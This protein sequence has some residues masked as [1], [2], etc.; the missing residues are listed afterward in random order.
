M[1]FSSELDFM[2][3]KLEAELEN[4]L[5]NN[6]N[7]GQF[8]IKL[9]A[10]ENL[11]TKM[12]LS[13]EENLHYQS[14]LK[15]LKKRSRTIAV[16]KN[17]QKMHNEREMRESNLTSRRIEQNINPY[18]DMADD[19]FYRGENSRLDQ[20]V[21]KGLDSL[22]SLRRQDDLINN[23]NTKLRSGIKRLGLSEEFI[24]NIENRAFGDKTLFVFLLA[25]VIILM[26]VLRFFF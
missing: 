25:F 7:I 14:L 18:R 2:L 23:V 12:K 19:D 9:K 16:E 17:K 26:F 13:E 1:Q 3:E 20:I 5:L 4:C 15:S 6:K 11:L 22:A 8:N 21:N 10:F 24:N